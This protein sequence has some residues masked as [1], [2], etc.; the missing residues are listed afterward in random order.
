MH[1]LD[2]GVDMIRFQCRRCGYD[3]GWIEDEQTVSRNKRGIPCPDCNETASGR[4]I[5]GE[6]L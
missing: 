1:V 5:L 6:H 2:A 3:T 4:N